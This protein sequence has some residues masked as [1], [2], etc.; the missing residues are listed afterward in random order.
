VEVEATREFA[1]RKT[2]E[3]S[4][5]LPGP[6]S[7]LGHALAIAGEKTEARKILQRLLK[8]QDP[9][10]VDI[11]RIYAGLREPEEALRWLEISVKRRNLHLLTV[12]ADRRFEHLRTEAR[13][14]NIFKEMGLSH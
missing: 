3:Y 14:Q 4:G 5:N 9:P 10:D 1:Y 12:P 6:M 13:F 7:F 11:A 2:C 8:T